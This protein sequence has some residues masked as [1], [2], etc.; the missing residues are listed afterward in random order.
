MEYKQYKNKLN[1]LLKE[2]ERMYYQDMFENYRGNMKQT[3]NVIKR[4]LNKNKKSITMNTI[5][6]ADKTVTDS[7]EIANVFNDFSPM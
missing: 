2:C 7:T 3:W 4:I 1:K 6:H 5:Q